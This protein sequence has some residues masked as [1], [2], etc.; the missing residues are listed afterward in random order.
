[1]KH[2]DKVISPF[3]FLPVSPVPPGPPTNLQVTGQTATTLS[4][5]WTN[6]TFNGFSDIATF[7]VQTTGKGNTSQH[8]FEGDENTTTFT[9]T[10]LIPITNYTVRLFVRNAVGLEGESAETMGMT[11]SVRKSL[12]LSLLTSYL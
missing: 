3:P 4:I 5:S 2:D 8:N 12:F 10:E 6:P 1:M 7:R 9:L 11:D